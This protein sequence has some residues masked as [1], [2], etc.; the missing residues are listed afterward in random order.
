M[1]S[2]LYTYTDLNN[3]GKY[4]YFNEIKSL[5]HLAA[6]TDLKKLVNQDF[7]GQAKEKLFTLKAQALDEA[8]A[9]LLPEWQDKE[10]LFCQNVVMSA[11]FRN[12]IKEAGI[13]DKRYY[14][15]FKR[16]CN[17]LVNLINQLEEA[18]VSP[19]DIRK[20]SDKRD[21]LVFCSAWEYLKENDRAISDMNKFFE[22]L[23]DRTEAIKCLKLLFDIAGVPDKVVVHGFYYITPF[24]KR[25][26]NALEAAGIELIHLIPY[27]HNYALPMETWHKTYSEYEEH[28]KSIKTEYPWDISQ[29]LIGDAMLGKEVDA[30]GITV[31]EYLNETE[32]A[33]EIKK[34]KDIGAEIYSPNQLV[35]NSILK[36]YY[37]EMFEERKLLSY[38]VGR[39]LSSMH[40]MWDSS[41]GDVVINASDLKECFAAG[42]V[43]FD[44]LNSSECLRDLECILPYFENCK[45]FESWTERINYLKEAYDTAVRSFED[46]YSSIEDAQIR[47]HTCNPLHH[48][49]VFSLD[50]DRL[51]TIIDFI[52]RILQIVYDLFE[53]DEETSIS[54]HMQKLENY[55]LSEDTSEEL[56]EEEIQVIDELLLTIQKLKRNRYEC[57]VD[58]ITSALKFYL[59]GTLEDEEKKNTIGMVYSFYRI[60]AAYIKFKDK[61][62]HICLCDLDN[63]P[64]P[65]AKIRWPLNEDLLKL[66]SENSSNALLS[67]LIQNNEL[68]PVYNRYHMFNVFN[69][70]NIEI[71]WI[72][73]MNGKKNPPS[74]Y[75][76]L[77]A[78]YGSNV[79]T[80][81]NNMISYD[82]VAVLEKRSSVVLPYDI[83][84]KGFSKD[85]E[86]EFAVCPMRYLYGFVLEKYPRYTSKFHQERAVGKLI[87]ILSSQLSEEGI[88]REEVSRNVLS[89]FP[90]LRA[91]EKRQIMDYAYNASSEFKADNYE[92]YALDPLRF[93]LT[94][95]ENELMHSAFSRYSKLYS[96]LG[97]VNFNVYE[98]TDIKHACVFCPH[99]SYCRNAV[100]SH[101]Q[102]DYYD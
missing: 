81:K 5:P 100:Y 55:L 86:T 48:F 3:I 53:E 74:A 9:V 76:S 87:A 82:D 43:S 69:N 95:P 21:V 84:E 28:L 15:G 6:T 33:R 56:Y 101:E 61:I 16:S 80:I 46:Q 102:E 41:L 45:S 40:N 71:S 10:T 39:F 54:S 57:S 47:E 23:S 63:M 93:C 7:D 8:M 2:K 29:N 79:S 97:K 77:L 92:S 22:N 44:G 31:I 88:N 30:R 13:S 75:I 68:Q 24:Q 66:C 50:R 85:A 60:D 59:A 20:C 96:Q 17:S 65:Q 36:E 49:S 18:C 26:F 99:E 11:F 91:I 51:N 37:P 64:G 58:D 38:P 70:D 62:K 98:S 90:Y 19:E 34:K 25:F 73:K 72:S 27:N 89:L 83:T 42:W 67:L 35:A 1:S 78:R 32:F 4:P 52:E 14:Q 94:Y 12:L